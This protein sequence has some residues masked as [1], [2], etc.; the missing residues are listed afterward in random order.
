[1]DKSKQDEA[2][3]AVLVH[4]LNTSRIP[5]AKRMLDRLENGEKLSDEDINILKIEYEEFMK[6]TGLVE[7]NPQYMGLVSRY[8]DLY[9]TI[10]ERALENE[11]GR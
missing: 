9:T 8:V 5:R 2:T 10:I 1:M 7:R 3:L 6:D 4:S 11:G